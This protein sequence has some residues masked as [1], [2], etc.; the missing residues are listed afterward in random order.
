MN[1]FKHL[2]YV[3]LCA[4][5]AA[6]ALNA[7]N[8]WAEGDSADA[9]INITIVEPSVTAAAV[10]A[11]FGSWTVINK[12]SGP[13][14]TLTISPAGVIDQTN[15]GSY[16]NARFVA[17]DALTGVVPLTL[18]LRDAAF[19]QQLSFAVGAADAA[20]GVISGPTITLEKSG[21]APTDGDFLI[22]N[23][24]CAVDPNAGYGAGGGTDEIF[25][26][27]VAHA[28][29]GLGVV[30]MGTANGDTPE[31]ANGGADIACGMDI[32]T[33]GTGNPYTDGTYTAVARFVV[34][35]I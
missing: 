20:P 35:Y 8:A 28:T 14:G 9:D 27:D 34:D 21:G 23:W 29:N 15:A 6:L 25:V 22:N 31:V 11:N 10:D 7:S 33:D 2:K 30:T 13:A 16:P 18:T 12:S 1:L 26:A 5:I 4:G 3:G 19:N 32:S 17:I 24:N